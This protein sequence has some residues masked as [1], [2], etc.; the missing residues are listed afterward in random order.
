MLGKLNSIGSC[1]LTYRF[2]LR[3][4]KLFLPKQYLVTTSYFYN[5]SRPKRCR[6]LKGGEGEAG[7]VHA[8]PLLPA[9]GSVPNHAH[10]LLVAGVQAPRHHLAL[11]VLVVHVALQHNDG[12]VTSVTDPDPTDSSPIPT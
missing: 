4:S 10:V 11:H 12:F 3:S 7:L 5:T 1:A 2:H 9:P 8:D 6:F